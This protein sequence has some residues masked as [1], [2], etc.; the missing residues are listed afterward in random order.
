[1]RSIVGITRPVRLNA[2]EGSSPIPY[3]GDSFL[4]I[5]EL[6]ST[7]AKAVRLHFTGFDLP[8]GAKLFVGGKDGTGEVAA[9]ESKGADPSG[10]FWSPI[11][12]GD[13]IR[14]ELVAPLAN[15]V[16][17]AGDRLGHLFAS[18]TEPQEVQ[19][20]H[21]DASCYADWSDSGESVAKI[22]FNDAQF[23]YVCSA[24]LL[25]NN[26]GDFSP[27]LLTANHCVGTSELARTVTAYWFYRS[28]AC[29]SGSVSFYANTFS[30]NLLATNV[31][32]DATLLELLY[33]PPNGVRYA[34]WNAQPAVPG[35]DI[36]S[37]HHPGGTYRRITFG[38]LVEDSLARPEFY[39]VLFTAGMAEPGS[40]G[41]PL[42]NGNHQVLGQLWGGNASCASPSGDVFYGK[43]SVA[44]PSFV[45]PDGKNYLQEGLPDDTFSPNHTRETA[46][47][48]ANGNYDNLVARENFP[49]WFEVKPPE[50]YLVNISGAREFSTLRVELYRNQEETPFA[51]ASGFGFP[52]VFFTGKQVN[53]NRYF[54]KVSRQ[55]TSQQRA[56]YLITVDAA[57]P[58]APTV[59]AQYVTV[60]SESS[61]TVVPGVFSRTDATVTLEY[62][63]DPGFAGSVAASVEVKGGPFEGSVPINLTGLQAGTLYYYR[64]AVDNGL[65]VVK[66]AGSDSFRTPATSYTVSPSYVYFGVRDVNT[67]TKLP[68]TLTNT[69]SGS[70]V[71]SGVDIQVQAGMV[72]G[73][74]GYSHN[75]N[76]VPPGG[77][78]Q[79]EFS[80]Q[81]W[82]LG[83]TWAYAWIDSNALRRY[84]ELSGDV[85]GARA[86][87]QYAPGTQVTSWVNAWS[88][89]AFLLRNTGNKALEIQGYSVT[90][91]F[92]IEGTDCPTSLQ[93]SGQ[94]YVS[95]SFRLTSPGETSGFLSITN[96]G[97]ENPAILRFFHYGID[98]TLSLSRPR[99]PNRSGQ[100]AAQ[101]YELSVTTSALVA[102]RIELS[103]ATDTPSGS[104]NVVPATLPGSGGTATV[105]VSQAARAKRLGRSVRAL[106]ATVVARIGD[107][108]RT[109]TVPLVQ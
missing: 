53:T 108:S 20:C 27:L 98:L 91:P 80:Y 89:R 74:F 59:R 39:R 95:V 26:S 45:R 11:I 6:T 102:G 83:G 22:A 99:R 63:P 60:Q 101:S 76:S 40:S 107:A 104:C 29:N 17:F 4:S 69:G 33:G 94:C 77:S 106:R 61:A 48:L 38:R 5:V 78:C 18:P 109:L 21:L 1:M 67:V 30:T 103:C 31:A 47:V 8:A 43:L 82:T 90:S 49:D 15:K 3:A 88:T 87:I 73:P 75:C 44:Y 12:P 79:I 16:T 71:V 72:P 46:V 24:V 37:I 68:L 14:L 105:T 92:V 96:S 51:V 34:G 66:T 7:G 54:I 25:N 13:T 84:V 23:F 65:Q 64:V 19:A 41:G 50:G 93:P 85:S 58:P 100:A 52:A 55:P 97:V 10:E 32:A 57:V 36:T 9:F 42:F 28:S 70:L 81:P 56:K 86:S 35:G 62:A 2:V